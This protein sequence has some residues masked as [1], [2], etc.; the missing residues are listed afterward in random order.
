MRGPGGLV[1]VAVAAAALQAASAVEV[2]NLTWGELREAVGPR[3]GGSLDDLVPSCDLWHSPFSG[4]RPNEPSLCITHGNVSV[5]NSRNFF[6]RKDSD[7]T[8]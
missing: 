3:Q 1:A 4:S 2:F 5:E 8:R 6:F 7:K